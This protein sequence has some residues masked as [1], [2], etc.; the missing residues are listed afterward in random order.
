MK[1]LLS[2]QSPTYNWA[3]W[4]LVLSW[5]EH[6][7]LKKSTL[8]PHSCG[9]GCWFAA[10]AAVPKSPSQ[11][12]PAPIN[13]I[14]S[15]AG[16][17][18]GS[19]CTVRTRFPWGVFKARNLVRG[20]GELTACRAGAGC[21]SQAEAVRSCRSRR[22]RAWEGSGLAKSWSLGKSKLLG[23]RRAQQT[24]IW[25]GSKIML[26]YMFY[27]TLLIVAISDSKSRA[28]IS[29]PSYLILSPS[30]LPL[31]FFAFGWIIS[32]V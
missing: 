28:T 8:H 4:T 29:F 27:S 22:N 21:P 3:S 11:G 25:T 14:F 2:S 6:I 12:S 15:K 10:P 20:Y 32:P 7:P 1:D 9:R 17:L 26:G 5:K 31:S 16:R 19:S 23:L 30:F 18:Q 13:T 24:Y